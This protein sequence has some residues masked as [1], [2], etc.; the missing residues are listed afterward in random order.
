MSIELDADMSTRLA[1]SA[2]EAVFIVSAVHMLETLMNFSTSA[3]CPVMSAPT[4][5]EPAE[6]KFSRIQTVQGPR[7]E[8]GGRRAF[9]EHATLREATIECPR[10]ARASQGARSQLST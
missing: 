10:H 6:A 2:L 9:D 4:A 7:S 5:G 8:L 1:S 3:P